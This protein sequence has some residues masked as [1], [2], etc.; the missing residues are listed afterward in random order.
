MRDEPEW[1]TASLTS[2]LTETDFQFA[3]YR[4]YDSSGRCLYVG[5]TAQTLAQRF[6]GHL[7][8]ERS[9]RWISSISRI[10]YA[11]WPSFDQMRRAEQQSIDELS[12]LYNTATAYK[13]RVYGIVTGGPIPAHIMAA[14]EARNDA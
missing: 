6:R 11:Q 13:E 4:V 2:V 10:E 9:Q 5:S 7:Q 8:Q 12:P 14:W 3:V 1:R